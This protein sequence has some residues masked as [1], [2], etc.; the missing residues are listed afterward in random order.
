MHAALGVHAPNRK[1]IWQ[2]GQSNTSAPGG[3]PTDHDGLLPM[4]IHP[5]LSEPDLRRPDDVYASA[6]VQVI[7]RTS[8]Q[9]SFYTDKTHLRH[10]QAGW[11]VARTDFASDVMVLPLSGA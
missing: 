11:V 7:T 6:S 8:A 4:M 2:Q 1:V 9:R 5:S 3:L 10:G